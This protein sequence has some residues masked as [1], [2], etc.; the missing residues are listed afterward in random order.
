MMYWAKALSEQSKDVDLS[1]RFAEISKQLTDNESIIVDQL[2]KAQGSSV[3][4]QGYY[5]PNSDKASAAMRPSEALNE[6]ISSIN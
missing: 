5:L 4:L 1:D 3:D 2:N 6:I